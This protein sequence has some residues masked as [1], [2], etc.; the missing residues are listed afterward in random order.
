MIIKR[1]L[2][3]VL[4]ALSIGITPAIS[5]DVSLVLTAEYSKMLTDKLMVSYVFTRRITRWETGEHIKV[6]TKPVNS[7]EHRAF[8][9]QWLDMTISRYKREL[10]RQLYAGKTTNIK[11]VSSDEEMIIMVLNTPASIGYLN[12]GNI[13]MHGDDNI[14]ILHN[15]Q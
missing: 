5:S 9:N 8:L 10:D 2:Q 13:I 4:L 7:I 14:K 1:I 15:I 11:E 12:Y 6:F 3:S